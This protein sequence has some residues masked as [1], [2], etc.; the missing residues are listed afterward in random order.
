MMKLKKFLNHKNFYFPN[1]KL[2]II[3]LIISN[4]TYCSSYSREVRM[5]LSGAAYCRSS[6]VLYNDPPPTIQS[7]REYLNDPVLTQRFSPK[8]IR[9]AS[10]YGIVE[11]LKAYSLLMEKQTTK[12][13][14]T[15]ELLE[16]ENNITR[17]FNLIMIDI[18]SI[19]SEMNCYI[20]RFTEILTMMNDKEDDIIST[21]TIYAIMSGAIAAIIEGLTLDESN[22]NQKIV[23]GGGLLVSFFSYLAYKPSV[24]V[25]FR[26]SST[27]LKDLWNN[28]EKTE[29]YSSGMWFLM[30]KKILDS[31]E[32]YRELLVKRWIENHFLG[33]EG[34]ERERLIDLFFG[35]G[36]ISTITNIA[37]RREMITQIRTII[38]L[39]EQDARALM[40]EF[41][42]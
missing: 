14:K 4:F 7:V 37:N 31:D 40:V 30:T 38:S 20:D 26:P 33:D 10:A 24:T 3:F 35:K 21:N 13:K 11:D 22:I 15:L 28:P 5:Q 16:L 25:E 9:I 17:K 12:A 6:M 8:S 19:E 1:F 36:G 2:L 29:N 34:R 18:I 27:N 32:P 39:Y 23:I 42:R 41:S